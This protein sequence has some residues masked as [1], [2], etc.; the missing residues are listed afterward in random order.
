[1]INELFLFSKFTLNHLQSRL[2]NHF[3]YDCTVWPSLLARPHLIQ[4]SALSQNAGV[5]GLQ[6]AVVSSLIWRRKASF[7]SDKL[8]ALAPVLGTPQ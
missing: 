8:L 7:S 6:T 1:M 3:I 4:T 5:R 2:F